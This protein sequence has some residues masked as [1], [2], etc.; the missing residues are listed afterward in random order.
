MTLTLCVKKVMAVL[1][2]HYFFCACLD[3]TDLWFYFCIFLQ[4]V[5][6]LTFVLDY[7]V[8]KRYA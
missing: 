8:M 2:R 5:L 3:D 1:D 6:P 4:N 7:A